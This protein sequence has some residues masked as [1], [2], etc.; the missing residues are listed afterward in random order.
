MKDFIER[1][2]RL[3]L[4]YRC[5]AQVGGWLFLVGTAAV[6]GHSVVLL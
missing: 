2:K 3:L 6:T 1:N 4:F 5:A